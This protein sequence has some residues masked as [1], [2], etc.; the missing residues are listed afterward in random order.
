MQSLE[1]R[2]RKIA[3]TGLEGSLIP[4]NKKAPQVWYGP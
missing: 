3:K 4:P 2:K 1:P